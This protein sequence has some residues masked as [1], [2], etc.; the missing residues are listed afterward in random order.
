MIEVAESDDGLKI[1][2]V[3]CAADIGQALDPAIVSAQI[4]SG[5]IF[6]LSSALGQ[7]ITFD[8]GMVEQTNFDTFDAM[9]MAQCPNI[10]IDVMEN[11]DHRGGAG[12]PGTPPSIPALANAIYALNGK[13]IRKMPLS[14]EVEFA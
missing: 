9:R 2:N 14:N 4:Q 11:A 13:R 5:I 6:G 7:E 3:W 10:V 1:E 12:E 8:D